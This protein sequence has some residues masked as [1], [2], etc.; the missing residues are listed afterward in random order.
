MAQ[1]AFRSHE[2]DFLQRQNQ[3]ILEQLAHVERERDEAL[4]VIQGWEEKEGALQAE[5]DAI[6]AQIERT[7]HELEQE[8]QEANAKEEHTRVLSE[9]NR[10]LLELLEKEEAT[11]KEQSER[12]TYLRSEVARLL[13]IEKDFDQVKADGES[14]VN[15]A[16]NEVMRLTEEL[17][18][19]RD[20]SEQL[21]T[22]GANYEAQ[23][24]VDLE[25]LE[26]AL[27][28]VNAKNAEYAGKVAK[29]EVKEQQLTAELSTLQ[30]E[31]TSIEKEK[32]GLR[33]QLEMDEES[34]AAFERSKG[35]MVMRM[36]SLSAQVEALKKAVNT[37]E[38]GNEHL[39]AENRTAA[40]KFRDMAD[41][42]YSLMDQLRLNQVE[43]KKVEAENGAKEKKLNSLDKALQ[44]LTAKVQMEV[45]AKQLAEAEKR[46]AEQN[47]ALLKKKNKKSEDAIGVSQKTTEKLER[48]IA[49]ATESVSKLQSQNSYL[50]SRVD[51]QEEE[52]ANLKAELKK[53]TEHLNELTK[54]N[55]TVAQQI[56]RARDGLTIARADRTKLGAELDYI[57][58]DDTLDA[59]GRQRP[60]LIQSSE[61]T[62]IERL[63]INEFLYEA[64][65][66]R[67]PVPMIVEKIAHLLELLHSSQTQADQY[68]SDLSKS[69]SLVSALRNKNMALFEQTST[70]EAHKS[71]MLIKYC[72][73]LFEAAETTF[74]NLEGLNF[75]A[76]EIQ[77][78]IQMMKRYDYH[79]KVTVLR[80]KDNGL[81]DDSVNQITQ[82]LFDVPYLKTV[83]LRNNCFTEAA[84][85][86]LKATLKSMEGM[87]SV[88]MT[89]EGMLTAH[90]GNQVRLVLDCT[91]QSEKPRSLEL[92]DPV[93][94]VWNEGKADDFLKTAGGR[95]HRVEDGRGPAQ[96][97][98]LSSHLGAPH[99]KVGNLPK[100]V[101]I[102][103][104]GPGDV[105]ALERG[106]PDAKNTLPRIASQPDVKASSKAKAG[107][108]KGGKPPVGALDKMPDPG[109]GGRGSG[110]S[111]GRH[112]RG[113]DSN[114]SHG[115][116]GSL[117]RST[118]VPALKKIA[119]R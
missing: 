105:S 12:L 116:Q 31:L 94:P 9:Q 7:N 90:S 5:Y 96:R 13:E 71:R 110:R 74:L 79:E 10:H 83:D 82:V 87:T 11:A 118:S 67:N 86:Q 63:H 20:L 51:A 17:R 29:Q 33:S 27:M 56:E 19:V 78:A 38:R 45:E 54:Q 1:G 24:R 64:Q 23:T 85:N 49:D 93:D 41:K 73:N 55:Q 21:R 3:E 57:K 44:N 103:L 109:N 72:I 50:A 58:R 101:P 89:P 25:A 80:L 108:K 59:N 32:A 26:Q 75:T 43:L 102:G 52:K 30:Q 40:E 115:S 46:E 47:A 70:F 60:I 92:G 2:I 98:Q 99:G 28:V 37:A 117:G 42:V 69:N 81:S 62:L 119:A 113:G 100:G 39:Q 66:N 18:G 114:R 111:S 68:L 8:Q 65:Q 53:A 34:R 97:S 16:K 6:V 104:G 95:I 106:R 91:Q 36:E 107:A 4:S 14:H 84:I 15:A 48:Q 61:S 35:D 112:S 22:E 76:K 77:E 88:N